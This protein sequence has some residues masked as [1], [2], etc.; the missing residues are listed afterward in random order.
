MFPPS[1]IAA[2]WVFFHLKSRCSTQARACISHTSMLMLAVANSLTFIWYWY[3]AHVIP[4]SNYGRRG[5]GHCLLLMLWW[6]K[7]T[8][9]LH[10]QSHSG[11]SLVLRQWH[12]EAW[13]G[14]WTWSKS[15]LWMSQKDR[16]KF[17][18]SVPTSCVCVGFEK[19]TIAGMV[20]LWWFA[21]I[22]AIMWF[23]HRGD[24]AIHTGIQGP[25]FCRCRID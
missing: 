4:L 2:R 7:G 19:N 17:V 25:N 1:I 5:S 23:S 9:P 14:W 8:A 3:V 11:V 15:S 10:S 22:Q 21:T 16:H 6:G 13:R 18:K 12:S 24:L 20:D